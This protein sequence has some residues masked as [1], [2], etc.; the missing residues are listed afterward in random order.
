M[1]SNVQSWIE[2]LFPPLPEATRL[3]FNNS[4]H[5]KIKVEKNNDIHMRPQMSAGIAMHCPVSVFSSLF[6]ILLNLIQT[7]CPW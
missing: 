4:K 7:L 6:F 1:L 3:M 5:N 2:F